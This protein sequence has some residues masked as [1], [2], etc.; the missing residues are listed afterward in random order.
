MSK[1]RRLGR[2]L[3]ALL[4]MTGDP[5]PGGHSL[6][7]GPASAGTASGPRL[8]VAEG[9]AAAQPVDGIVGG[10][11]GWA[12]RSGLAVAA[13]SPMAPAWVESSSRMAWNSSAPRPG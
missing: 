11:L 9:G 6:A 5:V 10:S 4:G 8:H 12:D 3:E 2:G 13:T 7:A 1:E